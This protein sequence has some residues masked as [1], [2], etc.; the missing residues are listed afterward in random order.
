MTVATEPAAVGGR[1]VEAGGVA[2]ERVE[3]GA[4]VAQP[5]SAAALAL[6]LVAEA[7]AV[8]AEGDDERRALAPR[9]DFD[10]PRPV[11]EAAH[12][13][14]DG[15]LGEGLEDQVR[16]ERVEE[17][18]RHGLGDLQSVLE[19][20]ALDV[21][22]APEEVELVAER[23]L[24][25]G[26]V[27]EGAAEERAQPGD[28]APNAAGIALDEGADGVERVEEE[29]RVELH[30][31]RREPGGGELG[32]EPR[33]LGEEA[34]GLGLPLAEA[35]EVVAREAG[36]EE[37]EVDHEFVEELEAG[38]GVAGRD[39][40]GEPVHPPHAWKLGEDEGADDEDAGDFDG[41]RYGE[42]EE[43]VDRE[44]PPPVGAF[45]RVAA[46]ER[47]DDGRER[48]P[49]GVLRDR[50]EQLGRGD[51]GRPARVEGA[52]DEREGAE[53]D[54]EPEHGGP[55]GGAGPRAGGGGR[56]RHRGE[57]RRTGRASGPPEGRRSQSTGFRRVAA[58]VRG[59]CGAV[60]DAEVRFVPR[61]GSARSKRANIPPKPARPGHPSLL[62][63]PT[64]RA[65]HHRLNR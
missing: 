57:G 7:G 13:V 56:R 18:R 26:R 59:V 27:V 44:P 34:R 49:E 52:A 35:E 32:F 5:D 58:R 41:R 24:L 55:L 45:E 16:D 9:R 38:E 33:G 47:E 23:D 54:P 63:F 30:P 4:D 39:P 43:E 6:M 40:P 62:R 3:A 42:G 28:D 31:E 37:R 20:D 46:D 25:R 65:L 61:G 15:V 36:G 29:V 64:L 51:A 21:E 14:L 19:A 11:F 60:R 8:V 10:L 17:R 48:R 50:Q 22:V 2:V 12:A 53:H 1:E